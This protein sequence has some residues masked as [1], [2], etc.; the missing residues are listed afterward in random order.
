[1][2][3]KRILVTGG[4]G[5][6]GSHVVE[7]F[8]QQG[9]EVGVL[10]NLSTGKKENLLSGV[11][12]YFCDLRDRNEVFR[13]VREFQP[14]YISHQAAQASVPISVRD[15]IYDAEVNVI[16][17]LNLLDAARETQVQK[18]LFAS[19][20]GAIYG[21]VPPTQKASEDWPPK[22]FSPYAASKLSFETYLHVYKA[23]YGLP[24]VILRYG[25]VFGPRQDPYGEAG[26]IAI[27]IHRLLQGHSVTLYARKE[28]GDA[29]GIRD[30]IYVEDVAAANVLAIQ[31]D[32]EGVFN[33][34]TGIGRSTQQVLQTIAK[35]LAVQ[36]SVEL[37]G[38]RPGDLEVS[39]L[40]PSKLM[41][42][43]WSP[44]VGFEEGLRRTIEAFRNVIKEKERA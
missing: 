43:G 2:E 4:A 32:L 7:A 26:V 25:N 35:I 21:E 20:G 28:R 3:R 42:Y 41:A 40:N 9:W 12:F 44:Q 22:P 34:G 1:M 14:T 30:Y 11:P 39:I 16:G 24:F 10:D 31:R 5:F 36:P 13:V 23:Q 18:I 8:L 38:R 37:A 17:G 33:V 27:F 15:P 29:G 19:T 6:I